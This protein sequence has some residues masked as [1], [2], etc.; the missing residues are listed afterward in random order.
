MKTSTKAFA[1]LL[2][3]LGI[4]LAATNADARE[5]L[6]KNETWCLETSVGGGDGGG[7]TIFECNYETRAQCIASKVSHADNCWRNPRL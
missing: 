7:G 6:R 1:L 5:K 2:A 3:G 4:A